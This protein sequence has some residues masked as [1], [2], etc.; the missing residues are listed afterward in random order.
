[1][2]GGVTLEH[3]GEYK[4]RGINLGIGTDT[5]PH[6][7]V[8][9]MRWATV[10]CKVSARDVDATNVAAVFE[11]ATVGGARALGRDDLGRIAPGCKADLVIVD[12][13]HPYMHP[14]R[15]PLRTMVFSALERAIRDV[16]VDGRPIVRDGKVLNIDIEEALVELN[17][18]QERALPLVPQRDWA[19]RKDDE[20]FP[21][22]L[23][24]RSSAEVSTWEP[25]ATAG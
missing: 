7:F 2:R 16:Y 20:A 18:G 25:R 4:R 19:G 23:P 14:I 9:E 12:L 6:N 1:M 17:R 3:F 10:L 8:D 24:L 15:D 5:H 13:S 21:L 11:A 22:S